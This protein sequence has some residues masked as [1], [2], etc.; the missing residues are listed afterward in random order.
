MFSF[1]L[2][3]SVS[4]MYVIKSGWE[5]EPCTVELHKKLTML[6]L[7]SKTYT[8]GLQSPVCDLQTS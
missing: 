1:S 2:Q 7:F 5:T 6:G 3:K 8:A 4:K